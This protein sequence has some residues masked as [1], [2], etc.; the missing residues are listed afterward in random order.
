MGKSYVFC[1]KADCFANIDYGLGHKC[2]ALDVPFENNCPFYKADPNGEIAENIEKDVRLY[3]GKAITNG[4]RK[5]IR[6]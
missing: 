1:D 4:K 6:K 2:K 3:S 5:T